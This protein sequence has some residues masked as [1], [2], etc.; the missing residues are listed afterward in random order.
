[1]V[2]Y[3][4]LPAAG[5]Q[6][7]HHLNADVL[8][9]G[10]SREARETVIALTVGDPGHPRPRRR[11]ARQRA[12]HRGDDRDHHQPQQALRRRG[13]RL[14]LRARERARSAPPEVVAPASP[15]IGRRPGRQ[16]ERLRM[17]RARRSPA[18]RRELAAQAAVLGLAGPRCG[19]A[20]RAARRRGGRGRRSGR[21]RV[22]L[23]AGA[24]ADEAGGDLGDA[25]LV[26]EATG[27]LLDGRAR[28]DQREHLRI[29]RGRAGFGHRDVLL[30]ATGGSPP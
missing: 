28:L 4:N 21:R 12:D 1:M 26:A 27:G 13:E 22:A 19:S 5:L 10:K 17:T 14:D 16:S 29:E 20:P 25:L 3:N 7:Q 23:L 9:C 11:P 2:A 8:V 6:A 18:G 30:V 24:P 15:S